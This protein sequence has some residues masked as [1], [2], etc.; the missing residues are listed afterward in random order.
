MD[1]TG[2]LNTRLR[3]TSWLQL[4]G[5]FQL[6]GLHFCYTLGT[7]GLNL[8]FTWVRQAIICVSHKKNGGK[9][10]RT[11][12]IALSQQLWW[13]GCVIW[14]DRCHGPTE[15]CST[16]LLKVEKAAKS[17]C[18]ILLMRSRR[19][20]TA[21]V[22]VRLRRRLAG[23]DWWGRGVRRPVVDIHSFPASVPPFVDCFLRLRPI[24]QYDISWVCN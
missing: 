9:P 10:C 24:R 6:L 15:D 23:V 12:G 1:L 16:P 2:L 4:A 20:N 22:V 8:Q 13:G 18:V 3:D 5:N 17:G 14:C 19:I 7:Y 21:V 11:H